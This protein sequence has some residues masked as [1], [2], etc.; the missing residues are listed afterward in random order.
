MTLFLKSFT[1]QWYWLNQNDVFG[2]CYSN[3]TNLFGGSKVS[4]LKEYLKCIV[5][6]TYFLWGRYSTLGLQYLGLFAAGKWI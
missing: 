1:F 6:P 3:I 2:V 5:L 4:L